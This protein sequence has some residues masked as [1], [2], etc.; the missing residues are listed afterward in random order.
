M[1][2]LDKHQLKTILLE[3]TATITFTKTDGSERVMKCT[4]DPSVIP[5]IEKEESSTKK[6]RPDNPDLLSVWDIENEG[7]RSFK[8]SSIKSI[9][10]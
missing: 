10:I 1:N 4:L 5:K 3:E 9:E 2:I 8:L 6:Q 7:W